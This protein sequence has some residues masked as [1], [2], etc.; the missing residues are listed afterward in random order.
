MQ[1][2]GCR[3]APSVLLVLLLGTLLVTGGCGQTGALYL[4]ED[5][6]PTR[7]ETP[8]EDDEEPDDDD[9]A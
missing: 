2:T 8:D 4:P 6:A 7:V 3:A 1:T 9:Q 5:E